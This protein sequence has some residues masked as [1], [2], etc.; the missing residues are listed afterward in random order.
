VL[1]HHLLLLVGKM[2]EIKAEAEEV[3]AEAEE[4][5]AGGL[6][7]TG[8][9]IRGHLVAQKVVVSFRI[10]GV[11]VP[12]PRVVGS[13]PR[14]QKANMIMFKSFFISLEISRL[15]GCTS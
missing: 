5:K 7:P 12:L 10:T 3:E 2:I 11:N 6:R 4:V 14:M 13:M 15:L 9:K 1:L 8:L